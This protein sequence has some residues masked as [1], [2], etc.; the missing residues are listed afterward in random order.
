MNKTE[1]I[2]FYADVILLI[3]QIKNY[4]VPTRSMYTNVV[5]NQIW[6]LVEKFGYIIQLSTFDRIFVIFLKKRM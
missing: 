1:K 5:Q 2:P 4:F 3:Q 6:G